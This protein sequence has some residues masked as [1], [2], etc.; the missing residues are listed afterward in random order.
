MLRH[1]YII[2]RIHKFDGKSAYLDAYP[3][4]RSSCGCE[5]EDGHIG[6]TNPIETIDYLSN[7][8]SRN[9]VLGQQ[10]QF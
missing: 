6:L 9:F 1:S 10:M 2:L 5:W 3:V 8:I 7:M 4:F